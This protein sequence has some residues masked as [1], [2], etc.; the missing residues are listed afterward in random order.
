ALRCRAGIK[1]LTAGH[2]VN[3]LANDMTRL[4]RVLLHL[5]YIFLLPF[6]AGTVAYQLW[7]IVGVAGL[8]GFGLVVVIVIFQ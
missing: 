2:I 7:N 1:E 6:A 3:L 5:N 4:D 8:I